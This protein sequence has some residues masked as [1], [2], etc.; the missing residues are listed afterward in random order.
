MR[1]ASPGIWLTTFRADGY[2]AKLVLVKTQRIQSVLVVAILAWIAGPATAQELLPRA[3]WPS[4]NG[5]DLLIAAYQKNT[6]DIITDPSLPIAGVESDIDFLQLSYQ[7]TFNAW[8]RTATM[9]LSLPYS[10]GTTEGIVE[11][12]LRRRSVSGFADMAARFAVNL[13][14]APTMDAEGFQALRKN[15]KTIVGT[16][17]LIHAPTGDYD[18]T[19]LFNIGTNRWGA[20]PAVGIIWPLHPTWLLEFEVGA[21]F[22]GENR[23]FLGQSRKQDPILSTEFHLIKRFRPGFWLSLDANFYVGG[24]TRL[25]GAEA[26][27]LQRNSRVGLTGVFPIRPGH[28]LRGSISTGAITETGGDFEILGLAYIHS[29]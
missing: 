8:G 20:K 24:E 3:Y 23:D 27:N 16:S 19:K 11:G 13:L 10:R 9:Q 18:S 29:W 2:R 1:R 15:P 26:G 21:W 6:G 22:F 28:A 25:G 12:E 4:P 17:L 5:T 14:V 7:R